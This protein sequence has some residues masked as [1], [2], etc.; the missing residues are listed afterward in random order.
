[1]ALPEDDRM[2][3]ARSVKALWESI[4]RSQVAS[5]GAT[6]LMLVALSTVSGILVAR[7]LG[8]TG[9]GEFAVAILWPS[10]IAAFGM[11]GVKEALTYARARA[12]YPQAVLVGTA[13]ELAFVQSVLLVILGGLLIPWLTRAQSQVVTQAGLMFLLVIPANLVAQY[14]LG[15]LQGSLE[16]PVFNMLRLTVGIVYLV[17]LLVLWAMTAMS[18]WNVTL[19]LLAANTCTALAALLVILRKCGVQWTFEFSLYR[20]ILSYGLRSHVGSMSSI[21]NQRADQMLMAVLVAPEQLGWYAVAVNISSLAR[22]PSGVFATLAFPKVAAATHAEQRR[23]TGL[24]SR[25][26]ATSSCGVGLV[27]M[28]TL[29]IL[30]PLVYGSA[31]T[32]SILPAE[33]LVVATIVVA[34]GQAWAGSLRGLGRPSEPAKA[35]LISLIATV[36]GLVLLLEP[37]GIVG[38]ALTSLAAYLMAASY[39]YL[40]LHRL[41]AMGLRD[42]LTPVP[43]ATIRDRLAV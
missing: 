18:V 10:V 6:D 32:P 4:R 35:E 9:R 31:Y 21:V 16:I 39:M 7:Q 40:Q 43:L 28:F 13:L 30:V 3:R 23:L 42:L 22:L 19:G 37:F 24:Y 17:A 20:R 33:I 11:L 25:L 12:S 27:L 5:T 14:A 29:P 41:L 38:A 36:V 8:P 15:L 34:V 26:N 2:A 1:V